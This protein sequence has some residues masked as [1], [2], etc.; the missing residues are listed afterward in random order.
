MSSLPSR[1]IFAL[2]ASLGIFG[3]AGTAM[4]DA[5]QAPFKVG[6]VFSYTGGSGEGPTLFDTGIATYI[7]EHGD[8]A[9]G[10]KVVFIKR[11][12][13]G[14]APE[15][16]RRQ[17]QD[18]LINEKVDLLAGLLYTPNA[19]AVADMSTQAK[20]AL[21]VVNAATSGILA[22]NPYAFRFGITTAQITSPL[23]AY[24]VKSGAKTAYV[25]Y[26]GY[27]PG[28]DAGN[29]F[30]KGFTAAGGS[31][32]GEVQIPIEAHDFSAYLQRVKETHPDVLFVFLNGIGTAPAFLRSYRQSGLADTVK[33]YATGDLADDAKL[34]A[35]GDDAVG[36]ISASNYYVTLDSPA[37]AKFVADYRSLSPASLK[38][39]DFV[40]VSAYDTVAAIYRLV[41]AQKG[42]VDLDKTV[43]ILSH[44][45]LKSPRGDFAIDP[46]TRDA[47]QNIYV[48]RTEKHNGI[49]SNVRIAT[50][51]MVKDPNEH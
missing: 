17:A 15:I 3:S 31:I 39:P 9:G 5:D 27:G 42:N 51:P 46:Q 29:S 6:I 14:I 41:D 18:L 34:K 8:M 4:T 23:G 12:D 44:M 10:R 48:L 32:V 40:S 16:A 30:K 2:L 13:T 25:M 45:K 47:V 36:I 1:R 50:I 22:K 24:A 7:K 33:L 20:T 11:D 28:I 35:T 37:N 49:V 21:L 43:D 38:D 26:H 19:V